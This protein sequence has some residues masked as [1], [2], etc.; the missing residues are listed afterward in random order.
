M[1][2]PLHTQAIA[3]M[4]MWVGACA[5]VEAATVSERG[6]REGAGTKDASAAAP[7][8]RATD[9]LVRAALGAAADA[10]CSGCLAARRAAQHLGKAG[11][12][13]DRCMRVLSK[14]TLLQ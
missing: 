2:P 8:T 14:P 4:C 11:S 10:M 6:S 13:I 9:E 3:D 1:L 7:P 5:Q 12:H